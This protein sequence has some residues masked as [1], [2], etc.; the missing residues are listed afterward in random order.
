MAMTRG[1]TR[2]SNRPRP[3][4]DGET[5][6]PDDEGEKRGPNEIENMKSSLNSTLRKLSY[7]HKA[8]RDILQASKIDQ[9][10]RQFDLLRTKTEEGY[11]IVH[12][13]QG[14]CIEQGEDE[15][16]IDNWSKET[17][18]QIQLFEDGIF[19]LDSKLLEVEQKKLEKER[20]GQLK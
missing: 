6:E 12:E 13:I 2:E 8:T 19:E 16:E 11:N 7:Y 9:L 20:S 3:D 4:D 10:K 5:R 15:I 17:K 1:K 14:L 18:A